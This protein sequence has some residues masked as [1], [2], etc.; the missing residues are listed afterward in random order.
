[1]APTRTSAPP[2]RLAWD[3]WQDSPVAKRLLPATERRDGYTVIWVPPPF[4]QEFLDLAQALRLY[5]IYF[6]KSKR[7]LGPAQLD[8]WQD[9]AQATQA[10]I[11]ALQ[12]K[13][14]V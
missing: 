13:E 8:A 6:H 9:W 7:A 3:Q 2:A 14:H 12:E 4:R 1:M 5:D 11:A 10:L